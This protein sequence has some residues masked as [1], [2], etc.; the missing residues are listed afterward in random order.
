LLALLTLFLSN[1][2][3]AARAVEL[4]VQFGALERLLAEQVFTQ[5]GRRYVRGD[6]ANKCNFAYLEKPQVQG[7]DGRLLIRAK[8]TGRSSLNMFGQCVGLGDA[9]NVLI[10]ARPDY[11]D[12][13]LRLQ[14]VKVSSDG[15]SGY[16]IRRVC[17]AMETSLAHDFRYPIESEARKT[18]EDTSSQPAYKREVRGFTVP[19][20]RVSPDALVFVLD[21]QLTVK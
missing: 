7:K 1:I 21:F 13:N 6:K 10:L 17:E 8:F 15:K 16:Y 3:P 12:G 19:E 11:K 20:I 2:V 9:F 18:L 4:H 14:D 5:E